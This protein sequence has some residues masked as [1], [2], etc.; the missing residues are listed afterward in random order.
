MSF[1]VP[2]NQVSVNVF[3]TTAPVT[4][5]ATLDGSLI[6]MQ[7]QVQL[8]SGTSASV[9][10]NMGNT[11]SMVP[12]A[13]PGVS[14]RHVETWY[15]LSAVAGVTTVTL[16]TG[17]GTSV[18]VAGGL[19][20]WAG[21]ATAARASASLNNPSSLSPAA[22]AATPAI[23]D[24]VIGQIAYQASVAS[25]QQEHL[26]DGTYTALPRVTR[27]TTNMWAGAYK[28]ATAATPTGP[29]WTMDAAVGTGELT[30]VFTQA[31]G[32]PTAA[33]TS[34]SAGLVTSFDGSG[35]TANG[36]ATIA[37][38]A[39]TYGDG[40]TGSGVTPSHT[41]AQAGTYSVQLTVT[42]S[43]GQTGTTSHSVT[44]TAP[45]A[46]A[47][48]VALVAAAGWTVVGASGSAVT[49]VSDNDQATYVVSPATPTT[50]S[51]FRVRLGALITPAAG[52][53]MTVTVEADVVGGTGTLAAKLYEGATVRA[54][55]AAQGLAVG[56]AGTSLT[57]TLSFTFPAASIANV[58]NWNSLEVEVA[59]SAA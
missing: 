25:T 32:A 18:N 28:V 22:A 49:A 10:D 31:A 20:E 13:N 55:A 40:T 21:G 11:Y 3:G 41:Y 6:V 9:T 24:L 46:Q 14:Q 45:G 29:S 33:F 34:S 52:T 50:S 37:A 30:A 23:G 35:S 56:T 54:L 8:A 42:D 59:P 58:T 51:V 16:N 5:P 36:G 19:S 12:I 39:W 57:T 2:R 17:S 47:V 38:Y 53:D 44:V 43:V 1:S 7:V 26:A 4:I 27:G 15:C 48:P